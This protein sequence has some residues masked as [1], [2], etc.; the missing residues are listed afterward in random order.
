MTDQELKT[1]LAAML[2]GKVQIYNNPSTKLPVV[3]WKGDIKFPDS[4]KETEWLHVCWLVEQGLDA[5]SHMA[6]E[7][8]LETIVAPTITQN[9]RTIRGNQVSASWQQHGL[10]LCKVKGVV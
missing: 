4:I 10:A 5:R 3:F 2:P 9:Q 1:L 8:H 6:F 7:K